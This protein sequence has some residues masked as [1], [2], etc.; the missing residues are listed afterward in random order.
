MKKSFKIAGIHPAYFKLEKT[1]KEFMQKGNR[2][3]LCLQL[4]VRAD[5]LVSI[6]FRSHV[7]HE[8]K[9]KT[10]GNKGLDYTKAIFVN[11]IYLVNLGRCIHYTDYIKIRD[12]IKKIETDINNFFDKYKE[13]LSKTSLTEAEQNI[14]KYSTLQYFHTELNITK[15]ES[16]LAT[17]NEKDETEVEYNG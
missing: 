12:N 10:F 17:S 5:L 3:Y 2:P 4:Q 14:L 7:N 13:L 16:K 11:E 15:N 6:P 1:G 8:N 9:F